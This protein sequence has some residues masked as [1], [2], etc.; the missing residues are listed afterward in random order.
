MFAQIV[1]SEWFPPLG[2]VPGQST[3]PVPPGCPGK[4]LVAGTRKRRVAEGAGTLCD[5]SLGA[6][7]GGK[8]VGR[9]VCKVGAVEGTGPVAVKMWAHTGFLVGGSTNTLHSRTSSAD[10]EVQT[11]TLL[12][13]NFIAFVQVALSIAVVPT[14]ASSPLLVSQKALSPMETTMLGTTASSGVAPSGNAHSPT[15]VS[16]VSFVEASLKSAM[17][18]SLLLAAT[19]FSNQASDGTLVLHLTL[20]VTLS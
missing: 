17:A 11:G 3:T 15:F 12:S 2:E 1:T 9:W 18:V 6:G 20:S 7:P 19:T 13:G 10:S 4:V 8:F 5:R 16:V 14:D